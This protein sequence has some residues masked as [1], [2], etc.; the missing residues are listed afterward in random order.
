MSNIKLKCIHQ[1]VDYRNGGAMARF[2]FRRGGK[3]VPLP[4]LP[5]SP[6]FM[7][8]YG[9]ALAGK[10]E[11]S[12]IGARHTKPGSMAALIALYLASP[13]FLAKAPGTQAA[14]RY[15]LER[16]RVEHGD[17]DVADLER[18]HIEAMLARKL[19]TP[20][21]A[22]FWLSRVNVLMS[23][24]VKH[25]MRSDNPAADIERIEVRSE[26]FHTW[27]EAE[28]EQYET[29]HPVGSRARLALALLLHTA[30]RRS[31][32]VRMG[33][34]QVRGDVVDVRQQKTG[35]LVPIPMHPELARIL[36]ATPPAITPTFLMTAFGKPFTSA[37]FGKW[38]RERC[39]EA[40]LPKECAAHGLRKAACR[41][42][43]EAGC[44]ANVIASISGHTSL[45]EVERY[46]KAADQERMARMG[47]AAL[48]N[49]G[50]TRIGNGE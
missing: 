8:A 32:V 4:G 12:T 42:L 47:M 41:R 29:R 36:A 7:E 31:D 10:I 17:K 48:A 38:F 26:G 16:M 15:T 1:F 34:K 46:T 9:T 25:G 50:R 27:T 14:Y 5:G 18:R 24:A 23:L 45:R 43:A 2:Y 39:D 44:S 19:R 49:V 37:G 6:E 30:Q 33:R 3:R 20:T 40:G 21:A 13:K 35:K 11:A 22:N 28:I